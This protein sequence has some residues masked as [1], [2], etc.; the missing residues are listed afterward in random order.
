MFVKREKRAEARRL[1]T[2]RGMALRAIADELG[3]SKASVSL[4]VRDIQLTPEQEAI[5][6]GGTD[7]TTSTTSAVPFSTARGVSTR[8][9]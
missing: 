9:T 7:T 8:V 1:W 5:L 3:V 4:W 6:R 2:E